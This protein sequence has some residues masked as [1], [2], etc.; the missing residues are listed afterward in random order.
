MVSEKR[1]KLVFI[2]DDEWV[3]SEKRLVVDEDYN[4]IDTETGYCIEMEDAFELVN[5]LWKENRQLRNENK[6][7][8]SQQKWTDIIYSEFNECFLEFDRQ[9][10]TLTEKL[11]FQEI[12]NNMF[13]RIDYRIGFMTQ[14][15]SNSDE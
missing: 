6:R 13:D 3:M 14:K 8:K 1:F 2:D 9:G 15:E 10:M 5:Q 7:L 4:W 12:K 11:F